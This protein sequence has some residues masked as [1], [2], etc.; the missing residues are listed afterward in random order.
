MDTR[1]KIGPGIITARV[2]AMLGSRNTD[3]RLRRVENPHARRQRSLTVAPLGRVCADIREG[4]VHWRMG[5]V[6]C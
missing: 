4:G 6:G 2:A 3:L 5:G 1:R